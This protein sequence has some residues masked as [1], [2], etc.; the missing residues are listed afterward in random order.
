[1]RNVL[2][3]NSLSKAKTTTNRNSNQ[4]EQQNTGGGVFFN[5]GFPG[6]YR[7]NN[8]KPPSKVILGGILLFSF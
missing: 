2:P 8:K 3:H 6:K 4:Q 1:M 5:N 7:F